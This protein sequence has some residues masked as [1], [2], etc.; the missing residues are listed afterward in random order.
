VVHGRDLRRG[1][2]PRVAAT[3]LGAAAVDGTT[4]AALIGFGVKLGLS[5]R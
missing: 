2:D 4:G 1:I 3:P 5:A